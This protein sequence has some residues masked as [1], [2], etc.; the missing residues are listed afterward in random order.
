MKPQAFS[1]L[2]MGLPSTGK[3]TFL[4]ALW[5]AV[6][7]PAAKCAL[8]L[9][10]VDGNSQQLNNI[11]DC[12]L[13]CEP[14]PRT[15]T[16]SEKILSMHLKD[17]ITNAAVTL[18]VPDLAG[19]LFESQWTSRRW[20]AAYDRMIAKSGGAL[21]FLY[22]DRIQEPTRIDMIETIAPG[23]AG[24][25]STDHTTSS[26]QVPWSASLAPT[27]V[28]LVE[29]LQF[30]VS[31]KG[32]KAPFRLAVIV[33]AWDKLTALNQSP[34]VWLKHQFPLLHQVLISRASEIPSV[35]F[36]LSAQGGEYAS[37][38]VDPLSELVPMKRI[39]LVGS[40]VSQKHDITEP[41]KW[42]MG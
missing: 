6:Q 13:R 20:P 11:R 42:L 34:E 17:S 35:V 25:N 32:R 15:L 40:C 18:Q 4:A 27:Q 41:V 14:V 7:E 23:S 22:P 28:K 38:N 10:H 31:R 5:H 39:Q 9:D 30:A 1:Y 37:N 2:M 8:R 21:L 3:T 33:S 24:G 29:L 16:H 19:E 26:P 12:W 36:G